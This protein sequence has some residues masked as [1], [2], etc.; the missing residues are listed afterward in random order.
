MCAHMLRV[1]TKLCRQCLVVCWHN[2][3]CGQLVDDMID[4]CGKLC[5]QPVLY[6]LRWPSRVKFVPPKRF[7]LSDST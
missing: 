2:L 3:V 7:A 1:N 6:I 5:I 4:L